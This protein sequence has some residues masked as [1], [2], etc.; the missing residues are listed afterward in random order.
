MN[1][2]NCKLYLGFVHLNPWILLNSYSRAKPDFRSSVKFH[3]MPK[4][5]SASFQFEQRFQTLF[6]QLSEQS[7]VY[8]SVSPTDGN[9]HRGLTILC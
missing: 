7:V 3:L 5:F 6:P 4:S 1:S 9:M 8:L 2:K